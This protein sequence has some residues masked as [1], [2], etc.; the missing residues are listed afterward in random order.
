MLTRIKREDF[1]IEKTEGQYG[2]IWIL[3]KNGEQRNYVLRSDIKMDKDWADDKSPGVHLDETWGDDPLKHSG[4][5]RGIFHTAD[6]DEAVDF[7]IEEL[8]ENERLEFMEQKLETVIS[9][10]EDEI[11]KVLASCERFPRY[12]LD[13][14]VSDVEAAYIGFK[15]AYANAKN[16][17]EESKQ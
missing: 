1:S 14:V 12:D 3:R 15:L 9:T 4:T 13:A 8:N 11:S 10:L 2:P 7:L 17:I 16:Q 5:W 6:M